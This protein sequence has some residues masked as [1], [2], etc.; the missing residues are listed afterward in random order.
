MVAVLI[1]LSGGSVKDGGHPAFAAAAVEV[2]EANPRLLVTAPGWSIVHARSFEVDSGSLSYSD[3]AHH[4]TFDWYP[5][6]FYGSYLRDRRRVGALVHSTILGHGATTVRYP[7]RASEPGADYETLISPWD[8]VAIDIRGVVASSREYRA[9]VNSLRRVDVD[10]WLG[11]MPRE[12]VQPAALDLTVKRMLRGV[13]LPPNFDAGT[14]PDSSLITDRYR[15]GT[16]VTGAVTC[17]WLEDWA[18]AARAHD[19]PAAHEAARGLG[20]A[21]DWPVLLAMAREKGWKGDA[22]PP[23]GN[24]WASQ[25]LGVARE[26]GRGRLGQGAGVYM[27]SADGRYSEE[28]PGWS[29]QFGCKAHYRRRLDGPRT[30]QEI[31]RGD[32]VLTL[33]G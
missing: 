14:L 10:T 6:R 28:G 26:I 11:A 20:S 1:F 7:D 22:L 16:A 13:P 31:K 32:P 23:H 21:P 9:I 2:A 17:G 4:L 15:L 24:G 29:Q 19:L 3:G 5:A 27:R 33:S 25:I 8:K 18:A 30:L 12:V